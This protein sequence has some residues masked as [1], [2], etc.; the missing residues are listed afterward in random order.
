MTA[1]LLQSKAS[2]RLRQSHV[3]RGQATTEYLYL[4]YDCP[5]PSFYTWLHNI[6]QATLNH[7][8]KK[9]VVLVELI[10]TFIYICIYRILCVCLSVWVWWCMRV[11]VVSSRQLILS[12]YVTVTHCRSCPTLVGVISASLIRVSRDVGFR[13]KSSAHLVPSHYLT[14]PPV[15]VLLVKNWN[16]VAAFQLQLLGVSWLKVIVGN[17]LWLQKGHN[18]CCKLTVT[19]TS[20]RTIK[21][22]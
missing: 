17:H 18:I 20:I 7:W 12:D 4:K 9:S 10:D 3:I 16:N 13:K 6:A 5:N 1:W 21:I 2:A 11:C 15:R 8:I 22:F 14:H 19:L